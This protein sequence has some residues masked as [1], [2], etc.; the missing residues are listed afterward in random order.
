MTMTDPGIHLGEAILRADAGAVAGGFETLDGE[1]HARI[2]NVDGMPP[3]LMN[4]VSDGDLWLFA[5]SNGPFTAGRRNPDLALFPYQTADKILEHPDTSGARTILLVTRE[6]RTSLWEPWGDAEAVYAV[7]R[8]LYKSVLGTR[9]VYEEVNHDLGLRFRASLAGCDAFGLVREVALDNLVETPADVRYLDGWHHLIPPGVSQD[10]YARLSY[11]AAGYMRHERVPGTPL[12]IYT[13]NA[14]ISDRPEPSESLRAAAAWSIGH[15]DPVILLSDRQVVAFRRGET[16]HA[17]TEV[18]GM[19]GAYLAADEVHLAGGGRHA[20]AAVADTG[21]DHASLVALRDRFVAPDVLAGDLRAALEASRSG[22]R[23]RVASG[24]ALQDTADEAATAH[25]VTSV[26]YNAMRGGTFDGT[27]VA[28][29]ADVADHLRRHSRAV[30]ARHAAWLA[31]LPATITVDELRRAAAG[32]DDPQ[33]SRLLRTYLPLSFSRRHGDPSRPWNRFNITLRDDL[34]NPLYGYEG[35]WRDI[36]QNWE[37][38]GRSYPGFLGQFIAVFLDASTADGYNPY[39]ITRDGGDWEIPDER[40]PWSHIGYWGDHQLVYLHRLLESQERWQ[41]GTLAAGLGELGYAYTRVPYRIAPYRELLANPRESIAFDKTLNGRLEDR[42]REHGADGKLVADDRDDVRLVSLCE[43]LLV[44]L[45][46]KLTNLVPDGGTWL[47]TQRPEWNDAN[48]ALAGWGLSVVTVAAMRRYLQLLADVTPTDGTAPVSA[49][50]VRLAE[51]VTAILRDMPRDLDEAGRLAVMD[52]LGAA[53]EEHRA[54]V[55]AGDLGDLVPMPLVTARDLFE[56]ALPVVDRTLRANR[57]PDGLY[58]SYNVLRLMDAGAAFH[59]LGLMLE[60]QVAVLE[61]GL[62]DDDEALELLRALRAS[63]LWRA[64][65]GTYLLQPDRELLPF[66]E[67][68]TLPGAPP[69]G[70][71]Q[72]FVRDAH[73]RWHFGGDLSTRGDVEEQL[74]PMGVDDATRDAVVELWQRTFAHH[75]FTGRSDRFFMFEGLGCVFWHMSSKLL[76]AVQGSALR[77][78]DPGI[79]AALAAFYDETREGMGARK[80]PEVFGAFPVDPHSHSPR[81]LGAQQPGMTG[82][83]KEDILIRFGELGVEAQDGRLRF[84][85]RLLHQAEF[86]DAPSRFDYLAL[87]GAEETWELPADSLAF[88]C[89]QV[90]VCYRLGD[91]PSIELERSDGGIEVVEGSE[92]PPDASWDIAARRGTYRRLTVTVPRVTLAP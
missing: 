66:L 4:V 84:E 79:A 14:A 13:L 54:A 68:N 27:Y 33:L 74:A 2:A 39:R 81:H 59:R 43:K 24:D 69:A 90:P 86:L 19:L 51:R 55:Y 28:P 82:Q 10:V 9:L 3:F 67:R 23:R 29:I 65:L 71:E 34:G 41:P 48:N 60:G 37:A 63:S 56:A 31:G 25:H 38:L 20:W 58:H 40:D 61:S 91:R 8:T 5:G 62:L 92:L 77:A 22:I 78:R 26:L 89:C 76:L 21:L 75:E 85:P 44:P 49:S 45:L 36:F 6:G 11:L 53:G 32:R 7:T 64:D 52:A 30:H 80:S 73:G 47:N 15:A 42:V 35:N 17:E 57:R 12:G 72:L 87:D 88:T 18:R 1:R 70:S 46:T 16:V 83:A 50:V